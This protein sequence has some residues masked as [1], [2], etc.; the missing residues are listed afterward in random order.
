MIMRLLT[1]ILFL[2]LIIL[3]TAAS[4]DSNGWYLAV[5]AGQSRFSGTGDLNSV[6]YAPI[7]DTKDTGYRFSGGYQFNQ[8]FGLEAGYV[9]FG[10]V[11]GN[12]TYIGPFPPPGSNT[13]G[14]LCQF[15]YGVSSNLK[16]HGWTLVF[17]GTYP[18]DSVWS[19]SAR[20]G[21]IDAHSD[22][23]IGVVPLPPYQAGEQPYSQN[24]SNTNWAGT[25]GVSLNWLFADHWAARLSW[26]RY[27]DLGNDSNI[28][29]YNVNLASLGIVYHF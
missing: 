20:A 18:F 24:F 7:T 27:A 22:L 15:S 2:G 21:E 8:Y 23:N 26:D 12:A 11:A 25:Y 19:I 6:N 5:D 29:R 4:A 13:C 14:L 3:S 17:T 28:G 16:T 10:Q 9:D 1:S